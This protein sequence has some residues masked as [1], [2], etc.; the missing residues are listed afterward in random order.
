MLPLIF[1]FEE[2]P[3]TSLPFDPHLPLTEEDISDLY[4]DLLAEGGELSDI[5]EERDIWED[6]LD[7][8]DERDIGGDWDIDGDLLDEGGDPW[9]EALGFVKVGNLESLGELTFGSLGEVSCELLGDVYWESLG[10]E[11]WELLGEHAVLIDDV[12]DLAKG[13]DHWCEV[14]GFA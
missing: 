11:S 7:I 5:E 12:G 13:T 3:L 9:I 4:K 1:S 8:E 10:E 6:L 14:E 2:L